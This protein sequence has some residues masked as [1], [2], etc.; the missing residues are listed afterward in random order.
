[1]VLALLVCISL[2]ENYPLN[3]REKKYDNKDATGGDYRKEGCPF[4]NCSSWF[5]SSW[6]FGT[7]SS[8]A[9]KRNPPKLFLFYL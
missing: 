6:F 4:R 5:F 9:G 7:L 2:K 3:L 8:S 1:M